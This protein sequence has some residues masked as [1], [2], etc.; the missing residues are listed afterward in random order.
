MF[1]KQTLLSLH[2]CA[3][4]DLLIVQQSFGGRSLQSIAAEAN[5]PKRTR[6][7]IPAFANAQAVMEI[8]MN[9]PELPGTWAVEKKT[10]E[11]K[12]PLPPS[13]KSCVPL[14]WIALS[15]GLHARGS[16]AC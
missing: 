2:H 16:G 14:L 12:L 15:I 8:S 9:L 6:S 10:P 11:G 4:S 13:H 7:A 1:R 5:W 3:S